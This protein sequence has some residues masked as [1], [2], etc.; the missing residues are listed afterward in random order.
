MY[1][2]VNPANRP[3]LED[4]EE[5]EHQEARQQPLPPFGHQPQ[6][7]PHTDHLVP[8]NAFVVMHTQVVCDL[9]AQPE[10]KQHGQAE[11]QP[12]APVGQHLPQRDKG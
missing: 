9:A 5:A 10:A 1:M 2:P 4:V 12:V 7:D 8:D 11:H 3:R 6:A